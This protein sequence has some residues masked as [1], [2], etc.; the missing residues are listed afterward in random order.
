[1]DTWT[2]RSCRAVLLATAALGLSAGAALAVPY[3][4]LTAIP[5]PASP[6]N[7]AISKAGGQFVTYD[8]A[9]VNPATN[10]VY[11]ADRS[12]ASVDIF[13][14]QTL[15]FTG[16]IGGSQ[17]AG[18]TIGFGG[19]Q[20]SNNGIS[21]P[22]GVVVAPSIGQVYVG[23]GSPNANNVP[24]NANST[25]YGFSLGSN[26]PTITT[27]TGGTGRVD[28]LAFDPKRNVVIAVNNADTPPFLSLVNG[29][30][31]ALI[32]Q[33]TFNGTNGTPNATAGGLEAPTYNPVTD[34]YYVAVP[35]IGT[36]GPGGLSEIDP[37]TGNVLRT[38]DFSTILGANGV[39]SP[40]GTTTGNDGQVLV[41]CGAN[42]ATATIL[43]N[44]VT[45]T[46]KAVNG[47][48]G[49]DQV[50]YDSTRN[51]YF[52]ASRFQAGGP[53]LGII[54]GNGN[55]LQTIATT[56]GDHSV[57]VDPNNGYVFVAAGADPNNR[58]C[59][60]GCELVFAPVP[61]PSALALMLTAAL[62]LIGLT[63]FRVRRG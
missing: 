14:A 18:G 59:G 3:Q 7:T 31:G 24:V 36:S 63:G 39:C 37:T 61:E 33:I 41:G 4:L 48:G 45:G 12:N 51:L 1:M 62:G 30:T 20:G 57:T 19:Q 21:G 28:E 10:L 22:D 42:G 11:L 32:K 5:I 52:T 40:S 38:F 26:A 9:D 29:S 56:P 55:L 47:I 58:V 23:N 49:E 35:Q 15:A 13:N 54:D 53:V 2:K 34:K 8:I 27:H 50:A 17:S 60:N 6:D 44:P 46:I 16:R 25:L 43:V